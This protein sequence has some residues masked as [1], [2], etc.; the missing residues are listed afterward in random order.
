MSQT[1]TTLSAVK[2]VTGNATR[3]EKESPFRICRSDSSILGDWL[4]EKLDRDKLRTDSSAP[5]AKP[6]RDDCA[7]G[8]PAAW[9]L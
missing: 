5:S 9:I 6:V 8:A 1:H 4:L 2:Q 3:A 7:T